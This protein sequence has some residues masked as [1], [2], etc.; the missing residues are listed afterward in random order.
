MMTSG[1]TSQSATKL[2]T[3]KTPKGNFKIQGVQN[4]KS[5]KNLRAT[6]TYFPNQMVGV[7]PSTNTP[8][9]QLQKSTSALSLKQKA[10][11]HSDEKPILV[12]P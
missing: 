6:Q 10:I 1:K 11:S 2:I 7:E 5:V 4:S 12:I 8:T 3:I 9:Q